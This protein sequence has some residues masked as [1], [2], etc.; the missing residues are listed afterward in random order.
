MCYSYIVVAII[1]KLLQIILYITNIIIYLPIQLTYINNQNTFIMI[2]ENNNGK[3]LPILIRIKKLND[4]AVIPK[5][6]KPG[7]ACVDLVAT[8]LLYDEVKG[9][10]YGT[11]LAMEIPEGW[12]GRIYPR[13]SNC[14]TK[15][16]LTNSVGNVD[17]GYRGEIM[18][19][20]KNT[21]QSLLNPPYKVGDRI[22]QLC[23]EEVIPV[24]FME[25]EELSK[26]ERGEGGYG[27]TGR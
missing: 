18:V 11:G 22:A 14:K 2:N 10:V 12:V 6:A 9:F 25:V 26:T 24:E 7:D 23:I 4:N 8:S 20:Y 17:S 1:E 5:Y 21:N 19:V 15:A 16:Y 3:H 27:H 13:S